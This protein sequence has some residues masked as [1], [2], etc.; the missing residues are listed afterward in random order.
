[1]WLRREGR[2]RAW[3]EETETRVLSRYG[4]ALQCRHSIGAGDTVVIVR[5]DNGRRANARVSYCQYD[6]EGRREVGIEFL[7]SDNFWGVDW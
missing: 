4:A 1:V 3:E 2:G 6:A 7:S 5:K